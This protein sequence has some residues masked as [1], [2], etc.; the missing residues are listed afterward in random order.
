MALTA[1]THVRLTSL[2]AFMVP[3][4]MLWLPSG[5]GWGTAILLLGGFWTLSIWARE[6]VAPASARW[7]ALAFVLMA[8]V[9][10]HGSDWSRGAS[11]LNKPSRYLF[12]LPCLFYALRFPPRHQALLAGIAFGAAAGGLRALYDVQV[13]GRERPWTDALGSANA[14]QLGN[15]CGLLGLMCWL[16]VLIYWRRWDWPRR[17]MVM[18]CG[19][20]GLTG[21]LL[22]QTRGGWLTLALCAPLLLYLLA[23]EMSW[24]RAGGG[25]LLIL[26]MLLPLGWQMSDT[27]E[28]RL[29]W[30]IDETRNYQRSNE[31]DNSVGHRLAHWQLAWDMGRDKPLTGWGEA[32]YAAEKARRV[33]AGNAPPAVLGYGHAHNEVLDQ[34]AKRGLIGVGGLLVLYGVPLALFW[35]RRKAHEHPDPA[36]LDRLCLRLIGILIPLAFMG[37]G[38]TQVFFAHYNGVV[39]YMA[40]VILVLAALKGLAPHTELL[41]RVTAAAS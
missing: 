31:A 1:E 4:L 18:L 39:I 27:L 20:L 34:F 11:V 37:F 35:P 24:R 40:L 6:P 17:S 26:G 14:I 9:W 38:L 22:S 7:L 33:A 12:A 5:Y 29:N 32:G 28:Q 3:A 21:S 2:S 16:Q 41:N 13:L 19:L 25:A 10:L 36:Q 15:L 8:L 23:R 30:A